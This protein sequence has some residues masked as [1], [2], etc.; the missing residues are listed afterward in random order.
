MP[1][2]ESFHQLCPYGTLYPELVTVLIAH[3][4]RMSSTLLHNRYHGTPMLY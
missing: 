4:I 3:V 2:S 1:P